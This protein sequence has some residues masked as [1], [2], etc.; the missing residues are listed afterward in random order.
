[1]T[2]P[3]D[4]RII[5]M[6]DSYDIVNINPRTRA[7]PGGAF[8]KVQEVWFKTKPSGVTGTIDIDAADFGPE[9]VNAL[10]AAE[11]ANIERIRNL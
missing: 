5:F 8:T 10:V 2:E 7:A 4:E 11:A 3:I 1:M 6:A 9:R